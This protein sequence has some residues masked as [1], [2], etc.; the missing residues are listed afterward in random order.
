LSHN[1]KIEEKIRI[2]AAGKKMFVDAVKHLEPKLAMPFADQYVIAGSRSHLNK[3]S[4]HPPCPSAAADYLKGTGYE[5]RV[6]LLSSTQSYDLDTGVKTPNTPYVA[7]TE[8]DRE[9]Y[10]RKELADKKYD[11]ELLQFRD[12]VPIGRLFEYARA[13]MWGAQTRQKYFPNT[14]LYFEVSDRKLL[15][16]IDLSK[17]GVEEIKGTPELV[18][19]YIKLTATSTLFSLML[20][21]HISWN[22]ADGALFIDYEREPNTYDTQVYALINFLT[23]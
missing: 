16:K 7:K 19:P 10:I 4:P 15:F 9:E 22:M 8:E 18:K 14:H 2:A 5:N 12:V 21:N 1:Q 11:H 3:Y 6:L 17:E 13:R 20:I 23:V